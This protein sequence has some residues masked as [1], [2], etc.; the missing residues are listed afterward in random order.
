MQR[1]VSSCLMAVLLASIGWPSRGAS[2]SE[3]IEQV[4][5][6]IVG[7]GTFEP[8]RRP[9]SQLAGTGFIVGDGSHVITC[10]H[11]VKPFAEPVGKEHLAV[12]VGV[13][14]SAQTRRARIVASDPEHDA[15]LLEFEGA[16]G[17]PLRL[18]PEATVEEGQSVA[19]TGFP[20][21]AVYGLYPVTHRG[22][23]SAVTPVAIPQ[24]S[25]RLLDHRMIRRLRADF[26][27]YQL[28]ATAYPGNSGSPVYAPETG[29]VLAILSS[30]FV[31]QT[32]EKILADPSGI[33]FAIP[34]RYAR[35]LVDRAVP[36]EPEGGGGSR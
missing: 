11:V 5:P 31:K 9:A 15:A 18:A 3:T 1:L 32:R 29:R 19:F 26:K 16:P 35:E 12:F 28:D 22:I 25:G 27:V 30:V 7:I 24:I 17:Q 14:R 34:I 10:D 20:I 13:G 36:G 8:L 33:T 21:G 4:K 6:S 2:L 23:I